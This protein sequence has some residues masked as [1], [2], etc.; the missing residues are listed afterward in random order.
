MGVSNNETGPQNE[1]ARHRDGVRGSGEGALAGGRGDGRHPPGDRRAGLRH[2]RKRGPRRRGRPERRLHTLRPLAR[3]ARRARAHRAR[4]SRHAP[5]L[6]VRRQ[7]GGDA[8]RQAHHVL[9]VARAGRARRRG[10]IPQSRLSHLRVDDKLR[11]ARRPCPCPCAKSAP[12][13]WTWKRRRRG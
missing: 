1:Q 4:D 9:R 6:G 10:S 7:R 8:G 11:R 3:A 2:A 12:S 13:T 5:N